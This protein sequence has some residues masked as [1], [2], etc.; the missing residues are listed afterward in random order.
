MELTGINQ[1][2]DA[3]TGTQMQQV[4]DETMMA[5]W[6]ITQANNMEWSTFINGQLGQE[7]N[8]M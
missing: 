8:Y 5:I 3:I 4:A 6:N 1:H 7:D 2:H